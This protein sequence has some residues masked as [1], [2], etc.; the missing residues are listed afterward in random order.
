VILNPG[1]FENLPPEPTNLSSCRKAGDVRA[2]RMR[3][4]GAAWR[5]VA[6]PTIDDAR[7]EHGGRTPPTGRQLDVCHRQSEY[8]AIDF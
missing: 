5:M 3:I 1:K 2:S 4:G 6:R 7:A 8:A